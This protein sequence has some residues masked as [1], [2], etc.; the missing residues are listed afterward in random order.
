MSIKN[1]HWWEW[2]VDSLR[3]R[4]KVLHGEF[5]HWCF[6]WDSLPVDETTRE[7]V[8]CL[9]F[10]QTPEVLAHKARLEAEEAAW[11]ASRPPRE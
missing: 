11:E 9:C 3:W 10:P 6:E 7:F 1:E 8:C 5:A 2:C 4:G